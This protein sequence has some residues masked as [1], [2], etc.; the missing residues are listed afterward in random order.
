MTATS[1]E[2]PSSSSSTSPPCQCHTLAGVKYELPVLPT[3]SPSSDWMRATALAAVSPLLLVMGGVLQ[4]GDLF[5]RNFSSS[6]KALVL[7]F[8]C[9]PPDR[10]FHRHRKTL[11]TQQIKETD[12]VLDVGSGD[13]MYLP[14]LSKA[15]KIVC[16]EPNAACHDKIQKRAQNL[17]IAP[18]RLELSGELLEAYQEHHPEQQFDWIVLGNVLC[19][20]SDPQRALDCIDRLLRNPR[21]TT[22]SGGEEAP[23]NGGRLFFS[24]HIGSPKG[25]LVRM[26]Q[27]WIN[28]LWKCGSGGCNLNRDTLTLIQSR[29]NWKS[30]HEESTFSNIQWA[31]GLAVKTKP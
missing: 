7:P 9:G 5:Q 15:K 8:L 27:E 21:T 13:G 28:P 30:F 22:A 6:A 17:G 20:V 23:H 2:P 1:Q 14:Y 3:A 31:V 11:L 10:F 16:L 25:T 24:E 26:V 29:P 19:E 12:T 4:V 18:E